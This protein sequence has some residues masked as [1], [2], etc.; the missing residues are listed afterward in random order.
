VNSRD[1]IL[2]AAAK[3]LELKGDKT[4]GWSTGWRVNLYAR[5]HDAA[6]AYHLYRKLLSYVSPD[7]YNGPDAR[8][9]GGTYPN[10]LDAHSPFQIDGNF[11][12][13]AGVIEMLMQSDY[14]VDSK[15][16][17]EL[18]L[19]LLPALPANWRDGHIAGICARGGLTI[20]MTWTDARVSALRI[21]AKRPCRLLLAM[22][23][24]QRHI[25]LKK[26]INTISTK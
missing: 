17:P 8:R 22:N 7:G 10:L 3:T 15:G 19:D 11:G 24:Q 18:S 23:G 6:N 26:G 21:E 12:G 4:T 2:Q 9:G 14:T 20:D 13:C 25:S 1:D 5:L 16:Q